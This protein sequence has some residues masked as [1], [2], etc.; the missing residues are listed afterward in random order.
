MHLVHSVFAPLTPRRNNDNGEY[1]A[2]NTALQA[3][4][5]KYTKKYASDT[6]QFTVDP[7]SDFVEITGS[8]SGVRGLAN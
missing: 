8:R 3:I 4:E 6:W 1:D 5:D 7:V 2:L